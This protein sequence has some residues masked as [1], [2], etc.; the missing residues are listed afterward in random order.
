MAGT[1]FSD[2]VIQFFVNTQQAESTLDAF[3]RKFDQ[4][5]SRMRNMVL[6]LLAGFALSV[7]LLLS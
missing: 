1:L 4:G 6:G 7:G 3:S 5:I 2:A